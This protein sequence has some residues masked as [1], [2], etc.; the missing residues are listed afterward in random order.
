MSLVF[1]NTDHS[2]YAGIIIII[3]RRKIYIISIQHLLWSIGNSTPESINI[4][5][6]M[7]IIIQTSSGSSLLVYRPWSK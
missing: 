5:T 3:I 6:E 7:N 2:R 4:I 1:N